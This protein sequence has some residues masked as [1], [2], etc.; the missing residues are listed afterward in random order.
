MGRI[1]FDWRVVGSLAAIAVAI[2]SVAPNLIS[3]ALPLLLVAAC[4]LSMLFMGRAVLGSGK[5]EPLDVRTEQPGPIE[6]QY[7][8]GPALDRGGQ[9]AH[10]RAQLRRVEEQQV[11][12]ADQLAR[13]ETADVLAERAS[14]TPERGLLPHVTSGA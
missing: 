13:L 9:V 11:A 6:A 12:L 14:A 2:L 8:T 5:R 10:L 7:R 3:T 1:C 4:P